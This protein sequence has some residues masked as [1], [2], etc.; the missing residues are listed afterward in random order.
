MYMTANKEY[1]LQEHE[2]PRL[3]PRLINKDNIHWL[4]SKIDGTKKPFR[5]VVSEREGGKSS[6]WTTLYQRNYIN[7]D[8]VICIRRQ[9]ADVSEMYINDILKILNKFS[10]V[11]I[12][13]D[14]TKTDLDK[15]LAD[16]YVYEI[17]EAKEKINRRLFF[18]IVGLSAPMS[19]LKSL[20][21]KKA[22]YMLFDEFICN[23]KD[24]E[25]YL[26]NEVFKFKELYN[27]FNRESEKGIICYFFGN[28]YS[29]YN[30]YFRWW[31]I[32]TRKI[33][34][35]AFIV[36]EKFALECYTLTPELKAKILEKNPLY[37]FDDSYTKY[38]FEGI[39]INDSNIICGLKPKLATLKRV[40]K[41]DGEFIAVS[42]IPP[43]IEEKRA[44]YVEVVKRSKDYKRRAIVFD[45]NNVDENT[46][47]VHKVIKQQ[48]GFFKY[49]IANNK[50]LFDRVDSHY[51]LT[52]I[53]SKL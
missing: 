30:P 24:D 5:S 36:G 39:S 28:P 13:F 10:Q 33:K 52:S 45:F 23:T 49:S 11:E 20:F 43:R 34:R 47:L 3:R 25:K 35:G 4:N 2:L 18:R 32:N 7:E 44:Y 16:V 37:S 8:A 19:R 48:F 46:R 50:V 12:G 14:F 29:V 53:Y 21:L 15:G 51:L 31:G 26:N 27:T 1:L 40:F 22:H 38:A 42:R 6:F 41:I 9:I 17:N